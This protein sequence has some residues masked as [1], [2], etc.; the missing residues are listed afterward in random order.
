MLRAMMK[1]TIWLAALA[2]IAP[3]CKKTTGGAGGGAADLPPELAAWMPKDAQQQWNGAWASRLT[4]RTSGTISMAGDP[5][6]IQ[7]DGDKATVWD[8]KEEHHLGF[9]LAAPC[10]AKFSDKKPDGATYYYSKQ[11][12]IAGGAL[13]AGEGAVGYR[14]GKSAVVCAV[15]AVYTLDDAGTCKKWMHMFDWKSDPATCKWSSE[16]GKDVLTVGEGDFA[17]KLSADGDVLEDD[18]FRD[19]VKEGLHVRAKDYNDAKAKIGEATKKDDPGEQ[20]KA[21]GGTPGDTSTVAGLQASYAADKSMKGKAVEVS[22]LYLNSNQMTANG[23]TS[24]NVVIVDAKGKL[25][26]SLTCEVADEP[27]G[28]TQYDKV[29]VKGTIDESFGE[30]ELTAC[31]VTKAP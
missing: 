14:K 4:M 30:A 22:G 10:E 28:F 17:N 26:P 15:S 7:I 19:L 29:T 31:T 8:G 9:Q 1:H 13:Q 12:V 24:Y 27:K 21:A 25:K 2:L 5:A 18:Q 3:A 16:G 11:F 6:A 23:K 20:A